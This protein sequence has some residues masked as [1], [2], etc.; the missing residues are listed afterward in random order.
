MEVV[1]SA[2]WCANQDYPVINATFRV[3]RFGQDIFVEGFDNKKLRVT[4]PKGFLWFPPPK[5]FR[6]GQWKIDLM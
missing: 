4:P 3:L 1:G 6:Q 5:L 2:Y